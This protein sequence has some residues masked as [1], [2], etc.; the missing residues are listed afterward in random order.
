MLD[1]EL[2]PITELDFKSKAE[3]LKLRTEAVYRYPQLVSKDYKPSE[4]VFGQI[5]DGAPWWGV[6]G[7]S[8]YGNGEKSIE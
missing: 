3:V 5:E 2:Q 4:P 6:L 7:I 1:I 8:Y